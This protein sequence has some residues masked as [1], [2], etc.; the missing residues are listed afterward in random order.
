M[1]FFNARVERQIQLAMDNGELDDLPGQGQP[2]VL[3]EDVSIPESLRLALRILKNAG[4]VPEGVAVRRD[5]A[6]LEAHILQTEPGSRERTLSQ[7]RLD[8]L[9][10]RLAAAGQGDNCLLTG[11]GEYHEKLLERLRGDSETSS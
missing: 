9:R 7:R 2:L 1:W 11:T 10:M 3:E 4:F 8:G 5:I 6:A